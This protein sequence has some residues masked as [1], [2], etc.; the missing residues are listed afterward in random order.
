MPLPVYQWREEV[1]VAWSLMSR[2][3]LSV[4]ITE[5]PDSMLILLK[6]M[7]NV[8]GI[9]PLVFCNLKGNGKKYDGDSLMVWYNTSFWSIRVCDMS[10]DWFYLFRK[11]EYTVTCT[12]I[13]RRK[14]NSVPL[15]WSSKSVSMTY[16]LR[17]LVVKNSLCSGCLAENF[18]EILVLIVVVLHCLAKFWLS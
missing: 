8:L 9:W 12:S 11:R 15:I 13:R 10:S 6:V 4:T 17:L 18:S 2:W 3:Y 14:E 7:A 1:T 5:L 16:H